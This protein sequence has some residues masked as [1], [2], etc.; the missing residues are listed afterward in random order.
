MYLLPFHVAT[1]FWEQPL[2]WVGLFFVTFPLNFMAYGLNDFTNFKSDSINP[3][4]GNYL[5]G[6]RL[7]RT[8][9]VPIP[10]AIFFV[11]LPFL[12][13]FTYLEGTELFVLLL[14][15]IVAKIF[16]DYKPFRLK[17]RP[18][19]DIFIQTGYVF[20][21][22]FSILLNDLPMLSWQ[23]F[24]FLMVFAFIGQ[25]IGGIMDIEPDTKSNMKSTTVMLGR[26]KSK[27]LLIF[28]AL[29]E[30]FILNFWFNEMVLAALM[31]VFAVWMILDVSF[32]FKDKPYSVSQMKT[33]GI[34]ANIVGLLSLIWTMYSGTL[35]HP[36]F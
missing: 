32:I 2:F 12:I 25:T 14:F 9:L 16:S 5:F 11:M 15:M 10:K 7:S 8:E 28:L 17:E 6:S 21:V 35:L 19:L 29:F 22:L 3:R 23:T 20:V 27:F 33:F 30:A 36:N 4:K 18:P 24:L 26:K 31:F 1:R 13:L 34:L